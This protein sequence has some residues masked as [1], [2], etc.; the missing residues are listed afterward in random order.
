MEITEKEIDKAFKVIRYVFSERIR[1]KGPGISSSPHESLGICTEEYHELIEA[2]RLKIPDDM[3]L[4][5]IDL[6]VASIFGY[7]SLGPSREDFNR[8]GSKSE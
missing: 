1:E 6:A 4:E 7:I 3:A 2:V 5:F 8:I